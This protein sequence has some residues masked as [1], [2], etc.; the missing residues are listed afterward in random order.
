M[1]RSAGANDRPDGLAAYLTTCERA[2]WKNLLREKGS[3]TA[4]ARAAGVNR[5]DAYKRFHRIGLQVGRRGGGGREGNAA[6]RQLG[7]TAV[8]RCK[9]CAAPFYWKRNGRP[10]RRPL[11]C[12]KS[13]CNRLHGRQRDAARQVCCP[14]CGKAFQQLCHNPTKYCTRECYWASRRVYP[15]KRA[16]NYAA[17]QRLKARQATAQSNHAMRMQGTT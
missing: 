5:T 2:Y 17:Y 14:Q 1:G 16:K 10:G 13:C 15:T 8:W 11:Y 4:A 12:S 7:E 6:W 9:V 3:V